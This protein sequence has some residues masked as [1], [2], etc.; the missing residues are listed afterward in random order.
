MLQN[1]AGVFNHVQPIE[2]MKTFCSLVWR[3]V[4]PRRL[5]WGYLA[6]WKQID[7]SQGADLFFKVTKKNWSRQENYVNNKISLSLSRL[8]SKVGYPPFIRG[9]FKR[10][11]VGPHHFI[12]K[13]MLDQRERER[14]TER[15]L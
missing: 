10:G 1:V 2:R 4:W 6:P 5:R 15:E 8:G 3:P 11:W 14:E 12:W 13:L 9:I 7:F